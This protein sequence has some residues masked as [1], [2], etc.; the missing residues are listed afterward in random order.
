MNYWSSSGHRADTSPDITKAN[1]NVT[2]LASLPAKVQ[3][4]GLTNYEPLELFR[5]Q[6]PFSDFGLSPPNEFVRA[7]LL[8]AFMLA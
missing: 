8:Y 1:V 7:N 4:T 3:S 2:F 5:F 6:T